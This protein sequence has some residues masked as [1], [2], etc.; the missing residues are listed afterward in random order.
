MLR[1]ESTQAENSLEHHTNSSNNNKFLLKKLRVINKLN[2]KNI[3][4]LWI[5]KPDNSLIKNIIME[6]N[7]IELTNLKVQNKNKNIEIETTKLTKYKLIKLSN[8]NKYQRNIIDISLVMNENFNPIFNEF[9]TIGIIIFIGPDF[10]K[11]D[12]ISVYITDKNENILCINFW[13]SIKN[14]S[15]SNLLKIKSIVKVKN[16]QWRKQIYQDLFPTVHANEMTTFE[17]C[18]TDE[19]LMN[20][21]NI[22][23][24][25]LIGNCME[26]INMLSTRII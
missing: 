26:K 17:I 14:F 6:S 15:Y 5:L 8:K 20:F 2:P 11:S 7:I 24:D 19:F 12:V 1:P 22:N 21:D 16:L 9:D 23:L 13:K 18:N 10:I 3:F 25:R 4:I